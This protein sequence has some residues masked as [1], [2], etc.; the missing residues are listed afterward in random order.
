MSLSPDADLIKRVAGRR[1]EAAFAELYDR[2]APLVFGLACRILGQKQEAEDVLQQVFFFLWEKAASYDAARSPVP[3]WL[4]V[5]ARSRCLDRL[6][7]RKGREDKEDTLFSGREDGDVLL[8]LPEPGLPVLEQMEGEERRA[9]VARALGSLPPDQKTV[10]DAAYF[11]GLTQR[12]ISEKLGEP[13]G[14]IKTRMRLG[15]KKLAD[16][17]SAGK[18]RP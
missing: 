7:R 18:K 15:L 13:L 17:L 14:T 12:E 11:E 4:S 6:R 10:L 3:A 1:D 2:H 8:P 9:A 5:I 16:I